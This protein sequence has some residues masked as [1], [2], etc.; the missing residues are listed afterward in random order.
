MNTSLIILTTLTSFTFFFFNDTATTEIY[1][2]SLHD[3]LPIC[4]LDGQ[5]QDRQLPGGG[6]LWFLALPDHRECGLPEAARPAACPARNLVGRSAARVRWQGPVSRAGGRLVAQ[7]PG[8]GDRRRAANGAARGH[9]RAAGGVSRALRPARRRRALDPGDRGDAAP[10][11][12]QHP[13]TGAPG[14][15]L[16]EEAPR[17]GALGATRGSRVWAGAPSLTRGAPS[18]R[19]PRGLISG[20]AL[21]Y[22]VHLAA[23]L[24]D[25]G[26]DRVGHRLV[27]NLV[28]N[29]VRT[30]P[31]G[32]QAK[33]G[34]AYR[35]PTLASGTSLSSPYFLTFMYRVLFE[36][37]S[38]RAAK[39]KLP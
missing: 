39:V 26:P 21:E 28:R 37:R 33:G 7:A 35:G 22:L 38:W 2:L 3:A 32:I 11:A 31:A 29:R 13:V 23:H 30:P 5:P 1:T 4:P 24:G 6:R 12:R 20:D 18:P 34:V 16:P 8:S 19:C 9:R 25:G 14:A 17:G 15:A 27:R 36:I 10:K